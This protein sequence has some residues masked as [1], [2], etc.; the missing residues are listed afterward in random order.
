MEELDLKE[1]FSI[2]WNKRLEILLITLVLIGVGIVYSYFF[3]TPVYKASTTLVLAQ[4]SATVDQTGESGITQTDVTLNSKLVSTYSEVMKSNAVLRQVVSNLSVPEIT[5]SRIKS[6]ISVEAIK[7]TE[8]IKITVKNEDPNKAALIANEMAKVFSEKVVEIYNISNIYVLDRA[9]Q[10][11]VPSNIN[12]TKDIV[13]F[14][15]IGIVI[16]IGYVLILN[17]LDTTIKTEQD[18]ES[19]TGLL[20]LSSIPNYDAELNKGK[21]RGGKR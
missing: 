1:L 19:S 11:E 13:I 3:V 18:V 6:N 7:N 4:S 16:S 5:E 17:M 14:A 9:E 12:H 20:V 15:F 10:N 21:R 8:I 2:F